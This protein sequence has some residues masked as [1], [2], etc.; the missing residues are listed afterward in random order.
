MAVTSQTG[1]SVIGTTTT[2]DQGVP[3]AKP[4]TG[5]VIGSHLTVVVSDA[6]GYTTKIDGTVSGSSITGSFASSSGDSGTF[7]LIAS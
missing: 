4:T 3:Q 7:V 2:V 6:P 5:V 1:N